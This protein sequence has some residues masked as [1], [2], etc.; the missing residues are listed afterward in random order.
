VREWGSRGIF[1][2]QAAPLIVTKAAAPGSAIRGLST[3]L[4][5]GMVPEKRA[6]AAPFPDRDRLRLRAD[7]E[8]CCGLCCVAPAFSNSADFAIDKDPG[9]ACPH[10]QS[11]FRCGI[12]QSLRPAGF[13]GCVVYDCF[14]AGQKVTQVTFA[15][16][17]WRRAPQRAK[18]IF[19]TFM[20]MRRLHELLWYLTEAVTM[21]PARAL[22]GEL[23]VAIEGTERLTRCGAEAF[24]DLDV[25][26]LERVVGALLWRTSRL[27]RGTARRR[28]IDHAGADLSGA[29]L[30]GADLRRADLRGACLIGADLRGADLRMADFIGADLRAVDLRGADL[31][32]SIFLTQSQLEAA[33]GDAD[34][35]VPPSLDRPAHWSPTD[36]PSTLPSTRIQSRGRVSRALPARGGPAH[37]R[38]PGSR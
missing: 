16:R 4:E 38:R 5:T 30:H 26:P 7:C 2:L 12:H 24:H 34:T 17:G 28:T 33:N 37:D 20:I 10:L 21:R 8:R 23:G 31:R 1:D 6:G 3:R 36:A 27:V 25:S 9:Q 15:G 29:D 18:R 11:D 14:G 32:D 13:P 19:E 22:H 35:R